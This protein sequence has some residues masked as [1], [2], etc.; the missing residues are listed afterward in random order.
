ME[1]YMKKRVFSG[2]QPTGNTHLGNYLGA[3]RNWVAEQADK[4]NFFCVVDLHS[5]TVPQDPDEL[6]FETRSMAA[7]LLA[8]G[9]DPQSEHDLH[10]EPRDGPC[11]RLLA[12]ELHHAAGLA[13]TDDPV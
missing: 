9:M 11:R 8:C 13:A 1:F 6:R 2:I 3:I 10:P 5:L 4:T 12:A 7:M